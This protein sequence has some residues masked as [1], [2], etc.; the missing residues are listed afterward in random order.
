MQDSWKVTRKLTV[1]YGVRWDY[2]TP[3]HEE[4]GRLGQIDP[5]LANPNAGGRLGAIQYAST[6]N[7]AFYKPT[8]P[9]GIGPRLGVAY[10]IDPKTVFRGG[11]GISLS[12]HRGICGQ[13]I[14]HAGD[15]SD[16]AAAEQLRSTST[17]RL[18]APS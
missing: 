4:Y 17:S 14:R 13:H 2:A 7:C 6:C 8:Y 1:D 9:Y 12:V 5:T 15:Y 3:Q 11:W 18:R 10:Q 16:C